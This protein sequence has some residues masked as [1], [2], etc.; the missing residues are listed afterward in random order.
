MLFHKFVTCEFFKDTNSCWQLVI[1]HCCGLESRL[2]CVVSVCWIF[3]EALK[4]KCV[5][6]REGVFLFV[7][8]PES[9]SQTALKSSRL[10][11][12]GSP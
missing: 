3:P 2:S 6:T 8:D 1:V 5:G 7:S 9:A 10:F 4:I 12:E 11:S